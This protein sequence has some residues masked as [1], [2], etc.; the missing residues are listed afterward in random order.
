MVLS[1]CSW[2]TQSTSDFVVETSSSAA[3]IPASAM[4]TRHVSFRGVVEEAGISV[5]MEGTHRLKVS[6][7]QFIL[8]QSEEI[9]LDAYVGKTVEVFGAVRPTVEAGGSIMRVDQIA[10]V[11][12]AVSS[13]SSTE[14][15]TSSLALSSSSSIPP[16]VP[17]KS[18]PAPVPQTSKQPAQPPAPA[19]TSSAS[20]IR[21]ELSLSEEQRRQLTVMARE[22]ISAHRWTQQYCSSH[23]SFCVPVH[24]NWWFKSFSAGTDALWYVEIG[25]APIESIGTG[26]ITVRLLSGSV[27]SRKATDGQVRVQGELVVGFRSWTDNRHFEISAPKELEAAVRFMIQGLSVP[28]TPA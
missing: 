11:G 27:E 16:V 28:N 14:P 26:P 7:G 17:P 15:S 9:D 8:L 10:E 22:D 20:A 19:T 3:S 25:S 24:K 13:V 1:G 12:V 6:D 2:L 5:Y 4:E 23:I 18:A 21:D